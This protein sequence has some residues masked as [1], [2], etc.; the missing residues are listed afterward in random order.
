LVNEVVACQRE[1]IVDNV[2]LIDAGIIFGTGFAP[3]RGGPLHYRDS[4]GVNSMYNRL[5]ELQDK[6][7]DRFTPDRAWK[8]VSE[9]SVIEA[10]AS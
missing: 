5:V 10:H 7:G 9:V 4:R 2:D 8:P 1:G 3:F 6:H